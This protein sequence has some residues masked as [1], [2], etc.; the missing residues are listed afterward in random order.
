M[1]DPPL[2]DGGVKA[3][4]AE[5]LPGVAEVIEGAPGTARGVT[6]LEVVEGVLVPAELMAETLKT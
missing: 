3:M 2:L 6:G 1:V 5:A 4:E